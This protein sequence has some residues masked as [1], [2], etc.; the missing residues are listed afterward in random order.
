MPHGL[1]YARSRYGPEPRTPPPSSP[2]S[3]D[4]QAKPYSVVLL[5]HELGKSRVLLF[6]QLLALGVLMFRYHH[7]STAAAGGAPASAAAAERMF[8]SN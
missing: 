8:I 2:P 6:V 3:G 1:T 4:L 7:H 5:E